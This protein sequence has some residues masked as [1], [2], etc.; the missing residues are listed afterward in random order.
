MKLLANAVMSVSRFMG[1]VAVIA[2]ATMGALTLADVSLRA[3]SHPIP[4]A[5]EL[6]GILGA[7]V[8]GFSIPYTSLVKGH[9]V[10]DFLVGSLSGH[11]R[12]V[13]H[14][15]TRILAIVFFVIA[16]WNL[17]VLGGAY[18]EAGEVT[19]TLKLPLYPVF[20]VVGFCCFVEC[21]ML[22][23]DMMDFGQGSKQ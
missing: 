20:Y 7:I 3:I 5:Y 12:T 21:L 9:V 18:R 13:L 17:C 10:M 14:V 19:L 6:V 4:G 23:V 1:V 8:I 11:A 16:G 2:L 15:V 22:F